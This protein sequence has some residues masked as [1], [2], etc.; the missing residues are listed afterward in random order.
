MAEKSLF[1]SAIDIAEAIFDKACQAV[2]GE[3][4][5]QVANDASKKSGKRNGSLASKAN[6][7]QFKRQTSSHLS[8]KE[9]RRL[10][11]Q[12]LMQAR[13]DNS[14]TE[15]ANG[16]YDE[17]ER[18][19]VRQERQSRRPDR[20]VSQRDLDAL[21]PF[22]WSSTSSTTAVPVAAEAGDMSG[23]SASRLSSLGL[24]EVTTGGSGRRVSHGKLA[25]PVPGAIG[26]EKLKDHDGPDE[27][28]LEKVYH[29]GDT[30]YPNLRPVDPA[31][32]KDITVAPNA[33]SS[34]KF[35][36]LRVTP[37]DVYTL[38][39]REIQSRQQ[40][41]RELHAWYSYSRWTSPVLQN[42]R[43][44]AQNPEHPTKMCV[45]VAAS[46]P[47][48]SLEEME[49][50]NADGL[51]VYKGIGTKGFTFA[52]SKTPRRSV[53]MTENDTE[54]PAP[55]TRSATATMLEDVANNQS[56]SNLMGPPPIGDASI[57]L[58]GLY[59]HR[60]RRISLTPN[61]EIADLSA[62]T[63]S[64][65][66]PH[67][68]TADF[69]SLKTNAAPLI[70][71]R[72]RTRTPGRRPSKFGR[73]MGTSLGPWIDHDPDLCDS[74]DHSRYMSEVAGSVMAYRQ[75]KAFGWTSQS[76][77]NESRA[78]LVAVAE[79]GQFEHTARVASSKDLSSY[80][81]KWMGKDLE[82]TKQQP[83]EPRRSS[84]AK[85]PN[86]LLTRSL[87]PQSAVW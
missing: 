13:R 12:L 42:D 80:Y 8:R 69:G 36:F 55:P 35:I 39:P 40:L 65:T 71:H 59:R 26:V 44:K 78:D 15:A 20:F 52:L 76:H 17:A 74:H 24:G 61:L 9:H 81:D 30:S 21:D 62:S 85:G 5:T 73:S 51:D 19:L 31:Q 14:D 23:M 63:D 66:T 16:N 56:S 77:L 32:K 4:D 58:R 29:L 72:E 6:R 41:M 82:G 27:P 1:S 38:T 49:G 86:A 79:G 57:H 83:K 34:N 48:P 10:R 18:M 84:L 64:S 87:M 60:M 47:L 67:P 22:A 28:M 25:R 43:P 3:Q 7:P 2:Y 50:E 11:E 70:S 46:V 33:E 54:R 37:R 53:W 45:S 68:V 75:E